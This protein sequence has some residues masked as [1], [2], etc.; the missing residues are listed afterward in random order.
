MN[1]KEAKPG[2][3][4]LQRWFK[5]RNL[6]ISHSRR[7]HSRGS[8]GFRYLLVSAA[9]VV[10]M[11]L[12][13]CANVAGPQSGDTGKLK[14]VATTTIV[15]D[16]VRQVGG[17]MIDLHVLLPYGADPHTFE[18]TPQDLARL[19]DAEVVFINGLGMEEFLERVLENTAGSEKIVP[20]SDGIVPRSLA[21][22]HGHEDEHGSV[23]E[24]ATVGENEGGHQ[25][26][27]H[28]NDGHKNDS[29]EAHEKESDHDDEHA[30]EGA[31]PHVW[32]DPANV[33]VWADNI[34]ETLSRLDPE[35]AA[36]YSS[37]AQAY[38]AEIE[39]L[40]A[41]IWEQVSRIPTEERKLVSDHET[42][43]YFAER[44]GFVQAGAVIPSFSTA[45]APSAQEMAALMDA[46]QEGGVKAIFAG[47]TV[48]PQL[49]Q[50]LAEDAGIQMV[51]LYTDS[52]TEAGGEAATYI[53]LMR[54]NVEQI[55]A[56][57]R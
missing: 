18:P 3:F 33:I 46:I 21:D 13:A 26:D 15:G 27:G 47:S 10:A 12:A 24:E 57:L 4:T 35:N 2:D 23:H 5:P 42:F 43:G 40:D 8:G 52:L 1:N 6:E 38:R 28:Q 17:E 36:E 48:N 50:Q 34:A 41:W 9:I 56:A 44:Y 22:E 39:E 29:G 31:D 20:V 45:A 49:A 32:F 55:V 19:Q 11:L 25:N 37:N 51:P 30:H 7:L 54:Y 14:V 53:E 16:V